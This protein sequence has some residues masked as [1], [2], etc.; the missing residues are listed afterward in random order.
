MTFGSIDV[1]SAHHNLHLSQG[2][3]KRAASV[4]SA[5]DAAR[6]ELEGAA[7]PEGR[8]EKAPEDAGDGGDEGG[9]SRAE[10]EGGEEPERGSRRD[11]ASAPGREDER[12]DEESMLQGDGSGVVIEAEEQEQEQPQ[13]RRPPKTYLRIAAMAQAIKPETDTTHGSLLKRVREAFVAPPTERQKLLRAMLADLTGRA[14][15]LEASL[16]ARQA[17][18]TT[19]ALAGELKE[20][21]E[22]FAL[23][24]FLLDDLLSLPARAEDHPAFGQHLQNAGTQHKIAGTSLDAAQTTNVAPQALL[25]ALTNF[26]RAADGFARQAQQALNI[27]QALHGADDMMARVKLL[28]ALLT[29][30]RDR[31]RPSAQEKEAKDAG[32]RVQRVFAAPEWLFRRG[33]AKHV[34]LADETASY[35]PQMSRADVDVLLAELKK[36]SADFPEWVIVP[37]TIFYTRSAPGVRPQEV[38]NVAPV[39]HG[40]A[41]IELHK[42]NEYDVLAPGFETWGGGNVQ[43][44]STRFTA[45]GLRY[46]VEICRD[47]KVRVAARESTSL[48]DFQIVVGNGVPV[49][50]AAVIVR[51][52]GI[53]LHVDGAEGR[54][55]VYRVTRERTSRA[56]RTYEEVLGELNDV[57]DQIH[58]ILDPKAFQALFAR[59]RALE[60]EISEIV[61]LSALS[62]Q[63]QDFL[64]DDLLV[65]DDPRG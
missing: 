35:R 16:E 64:P 65:L 3:G 39:L 62:D 21:E 23:I 6:A 48:V 22:M 11:E 37:G 49:M 13:Q 27:S 47:H 44:G 10:K 43:S 9:D 30:A 8:G 42:K 40:G 5:E 24:T 63:V 54:V 46:A 20:A 7:P 2:R 25:Q 1:S 17:P 60:Q 57:S 29:D 59:Q 36:L 52:G 33:Q 51:D 34:D 32:D 12:R 4:G 50:P 26:A 28:R 55:T 58:Q 61:Q 31:A 53:V 19:A 38:V 14:R 56:G 41:A 18:G 15:A 45:G